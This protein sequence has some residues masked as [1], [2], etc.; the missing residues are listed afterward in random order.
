MGRIVSRYGGFRVN[1]RNGWWD[2]MRGVGG[3]GPVD[4]CGG[5]PDG[6]AEGGHGF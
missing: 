2:C 4:A 1:V 6:L 5:E 3:W